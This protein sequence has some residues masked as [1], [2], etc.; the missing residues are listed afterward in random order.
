MEENGSVGKRVYSKKAKTAM[1]L[2]NICNLQ[3]LLLNLHR[4]L[5]GKLDPLL[6]CCLGFAAVSSVSYKGSQKAPMSSLSILMTVIHLPIPVSFSS[7]L[8]ER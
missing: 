8:D 6:S 2:E 1:T 5:G 3:K 7:L 4:K